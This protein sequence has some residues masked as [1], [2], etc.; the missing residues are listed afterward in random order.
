L[1]IAKRSASEIFHAISIQ[2]IKLEPGSAIGLEDCKG[3]MLQ[4]THT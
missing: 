2:H 3:G 4:Q 1:I